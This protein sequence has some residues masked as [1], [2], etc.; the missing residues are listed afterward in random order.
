MSRAFLRGGVLWRG[1]LALLLVMA[2][3]SLTLSPS[4]H[5]AVATH[6]CAGAGSPAGPFDLLAY[7]A[8]DWRTAYRRTL[9]L[10]AFNQLFPGLPSFAVPPLET[11]P[12]VSGSSTTV[13]PYIPPTVLKAIAWIESS[14]QMAGSTVPY[15]EVGQPL[16]SHS[17]A[18]GIMQIVSGME[19][20]G[21]PPTLGQVSTGS[22]YGF[23]V[24]QGARILAGKWNLAPEFRPLV[25]DRNKALVEDWYYAIWS[26]HGFSSTNHPV[27]NT[28]YSATRGVYRCDGTQAYNSFPYQELILGCVKNP[29]VVAG[30][31]LWSAIPV[32][33]P[34]L[35]LPAFSLSSWNAC[36]VNRQCAGMDMLTP[37]PSHTD[38]TTPSG[39]RNQ[40][41]GTPVLSVSPL[42]AVLAA[43]P[44]RESQSIA[45]NVVNSGT[46][47]L[48]WRVSPSVTWLRL[49][50]VNRLSL[51]TDAGSWSAPFQLSASAAGLE[52][53]TYSGVLRISSLYPEV[54]KTINVTLIVAKSGFVP[55]VVRE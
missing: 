50:G 5:S 48:A 26:Y 28:S 29:P 52:P 40:A 45:V 55:G 39:S 27:L 2:V 47:P 41:I 3:G 17:C 31:A 43:V 33:L 10:G 53:G 54:T 42:S 18:Y 46:G 9:E 49:S 32:T 21:N 23:N 11:G 20:T 35:A 7:E 14:W 34:N 44:D 22:H 1:V 4:P 51:G 8:G 12:R 38:P 25:G 13:S 16:I 24:A 37:A 19:N 6:G 36:S 15:G 30:T